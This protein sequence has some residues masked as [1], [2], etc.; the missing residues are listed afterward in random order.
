MTNQLCNNCYSQ[1][2]LAIEKHQIRT[3]RCLY[4]RKE[5]YS[6][7]SPPVI[8]DDAFTIPVNPIILD[9]FCRRVG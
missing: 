4:C 8:R 7:S 5:R 2:P 9:E 6:P 1:M 3:F